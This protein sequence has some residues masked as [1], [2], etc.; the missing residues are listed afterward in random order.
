MKNVLLT[1]IVPAYNVEVYITKCI[2]SIINQKYKNIEILIIDDG[3][4]D[5]TG[6]ICNQ[7][8]LVDS[9][10][11]VIHRKNDGL[12]SARKLGAELAKGEIIAFVDGDDWIEKEMYSAMIGNYENAKKPDLVASG[13]LYEFTDRIDAVFDGAQDKIYDRE[14]IL[15]LILPFLVNN[16]KN[17]NQILTSVCNKLLKKDLFNNVMNKMDSG[18]TLG[19]DGTIIFFYLALAKRISVI[20]QA[21]YH[22]IQHE[23]SMIR[24]YDFN[25]FKQ[26]Y[27]LKTC[28]TKGM[29]QFNM[30]NIVELQIDYYVR[31]FL[32]N[33]IIH[34]Y[35]HNMWDDDYFFPY[36]GIAENSKVIL[37]GAGKVGHSYWKYIQYSKCFQ[38]IAWVDKNY[39]EKKQQNPIIKPITILSK[40][41]YDYIII[42]IEDKKVAGKI[43]KEILS[44]GVKESKMIWKPTQKIR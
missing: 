25:S 10:I 40:D 23:N 34:F 22:Y 19:E 20:H 2:K 38:L 26:I 44:Y 12:V 9:R 29:N 35:G 14:D 18:L 32:T 15:K 4:T 3:S 36:Y 11:K 8:S 33:A 30:F 28:I 17:E 43:K 21:W 37:Y 42:A 16:G 31:A 13:L 39:K 6:E 5:S 24:T 41:N 27:K 7:L 1:V